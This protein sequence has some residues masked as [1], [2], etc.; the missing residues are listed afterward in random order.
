MLKAITMQEEIKKKTTMNK[1]GAYGICLVASCIAAAIGTK[2]I[3]SDM[4]HDTF[5]KIISWGAAGPIF[6]LAIVAWINGHRTIAA[7]G[8]WVAIAITALLF[9]LAF[10]PN[11]LTLLIVGVAL[12]GALFIIVILLVF[13]IC[14]RLSGGL[15]K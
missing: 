8:S 10:I 15:D 14:G 13:A 11:V 7:I 6:V 2:Q 3:Y 1:Y 4:W 5:F 9:I 12:K